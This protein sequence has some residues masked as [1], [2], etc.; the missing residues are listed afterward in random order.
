M[1]FDS[2][3]YKGGSKIPLLFELVLEMY[4]VHMRVDLILHVVNITGKIMIG[5]IIYGISR[6]IIWEE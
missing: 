5:S 1:V 2:V 3:F 6:G 4:Q